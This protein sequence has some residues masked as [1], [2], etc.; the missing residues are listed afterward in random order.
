MFNAHIDP[1]TDEVI[2]GGIKASWDDELISEVVIYPRLG[3][4]LKGVH[5]KSLQAPKTVAN[6]K[7]LIAQ[8]SSLLDTYQNNFGNLCGFRVEIRIR[9]LAFKQCVQLIRSYRLT[10]LETILSRQ[11]RNIHYKITAFDVFNF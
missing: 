8:I 3:H 4:V 2:G 10:N 9:R 11:F 5:P 1:R 6:L 7:T